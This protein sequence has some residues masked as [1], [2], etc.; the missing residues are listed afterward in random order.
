MINS[1]YFFVPSL[2]L[3][4]YPLLPNVQ[5]IYIKR[6]F[7]LSALSNH[8]KSYCSCHADQ[9]KIL[10]EKNIQ[11]NEIVLHRFTVAASSNDV[12]EKLERNTQYKSEAP[13]AI[14]QIERAAATAAT[15]IHVSL[16]NNTYHKFDDAVVSNKIESNVFILSAMRIDGAHSRSFACFLLYRPASRR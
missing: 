14:W 7:S 8:P 2:H 5:Y 15:D 10:I 6:I 16:S 12:R 11:K 13:P 4:D 3:N 9:P 1:S